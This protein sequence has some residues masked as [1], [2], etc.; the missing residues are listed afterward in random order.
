MPRNSDLVR[1][2]ALVLALLLGATPARA[3]EKEDAARQKAKIL[4]QQGNALY[5]EGDFQDA[6]GKF[7]AAYDALPNPKLFFN[8]GQTAMKLND[9]ASAANAFGAFIDQTLPTADLAQQR[10]IASRDL[11]TL[12]QQ[13]GRLRVVI[14]PDDA[15]VLVDGQRADPAGTYMTP[16]P[17][18]IQASADGFTAKELTVELHAA[19]NHTEP[20]HLAAAAPTQPMIVVNTPP[21][22]AQPARDVPAATPPAPAPAAMPS[23]SLTAPAPEVNHTAAYIAGGGAV[24]AL[25]ASA[26]FGVIAS[27]ENSK[28]GDA[29]SG[30]TVGTVQPGQV[31]DLRSGI[32]RDA[33]ISTVALG[34]G[35]VVAGVA[36]Y[37]F[38]SSGP[39]PAPEPHDGHI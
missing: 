18:K 5:A 19:E 22:A 14:E 28:L 11:Q 20:I 34:V 12:G 30:K 16:G 13:L 8:I 23:A 25:A 38:F 15:Q 26:V 31:A 2:A 36:T 17:H 27:G 29:A 35:A 4:I 6:L 33:A 9:A 24:V 32:K 3:V 7:R 1:S 37:L 10:A 39:Q 21:P